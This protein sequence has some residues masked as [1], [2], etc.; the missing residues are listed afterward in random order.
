MADVHL[1]YTGK[2]IE[3]LIEAAILVNNNHNNFDELLSS[4]DRSF[5]FLEIKKSE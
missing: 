1:F 3:K 4:L 2:V 5:M